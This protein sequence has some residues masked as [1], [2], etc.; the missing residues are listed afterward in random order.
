MLLAEPACNLHST[1]NLHFTCNLQ[2]AAVETARIIVLGDPDSC[3]RC[4]I[5]NVNSPNSD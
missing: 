5:R 2:S 4:K 1:R 3:V